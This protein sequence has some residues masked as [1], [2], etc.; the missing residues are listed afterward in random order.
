[1]LWWAE[2]GL[3]EGS[4]GAVSSR[5]RGYKIPALAGGGVMGTRHWLDRLC[6]D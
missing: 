3:N 2:V 6:T 5:C 1:M 4:D